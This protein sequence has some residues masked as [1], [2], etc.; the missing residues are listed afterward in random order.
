MPKL[1]VLHCPVSCGQRRPVLEEHLKT[2][3]FTDVEWIT[4]YSTE[5]PYVKWLHS[6]L[7]GTTS[8]AHISGIV[9]GYEMFRRVVHYKG[10]DKWFWKGDDDIVFIKNWNVQVPDNLMYVNMS[11]GVNFHILPDAKPQY[12][13]NNGGAEVFCFTREFAQLM[14]DNIDTRQTFDIVIH[15]LLRHMGHPLVCIPVA[16]QTSLLEPKQSTLKFDETLTPWVQFVQNF[17]P[18]CIK[19]EDLRNESGFFAR[20]DA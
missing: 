6:R 12:I 15:G 20:D 14:L 5:H 8:L 7:G 17:K 10:P 11:V 18:T 16:Q 13:G 2:R 19:Y 9:K 3:G 1:Y 4:D